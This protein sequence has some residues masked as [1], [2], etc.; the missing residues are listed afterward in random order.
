VGLNYTVSPGTIL[1]EYMDSRNISQKDLAR[2][3]KSSERHISNLI[4][5]KIKL[6]EEFALKLEDVFEDVKA[7]F[8]MDLETAYRLYMLRNTNNDIVKLKTIAEEFKFKHVFKGLKLTL[9]EQATRM[10]KLLGLDSF[11]EA[12]KKLNEL[13]YSFMEDGGD[14]KAKLV[15]LKLCESEIEIQNDFDQ[16]PPFDLEVFKNSLSVYKELM[17]TQNY[18]LAIENLRRYSN[19]LGVIFVHHESVPN[20]KIRGATRLIDGRPAIFCSDRFKSLD[21]LYFAFVHEISH[22]INNDIT[23][24]NYHIVLEDDEENLAN[25]F[26]RKFF[27]DDQE[28]KKFIDTHKDITAENIV[29]FSKKN[30][31]IPD[32]FIGF[33]KRDG[34][35]KYEQY[36]HLKGKI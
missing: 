29:V 12:G 28:Y 14:E 11:D 9:E 27:I 4:N 20:A 18:E 24:N 10:L 5:A 31:I 3:T 30:M 32:V 17:Y 22:I 23:D 13:S 35:L 25:E 34:L 2:L 36:N 15:W 19:D 33:L 1:K 6:T 26:A 21:T 7:E 16:M 8:W